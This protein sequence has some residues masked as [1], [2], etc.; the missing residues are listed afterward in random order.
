M[1]NLSGLGLLLTEDMLQS[2]NKM[3]A[4]LERSIGRLE[5][6][7]DVVIEDIKLISDNMTALRASFD[8]LEKGRLSNLEV[9][10]ASLQ[11]KVQERARNTALIYS[12]TISFA[13]SIL[14]AIITRYFS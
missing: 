1:Q 7:V 13:I 14:S 2:Q 12:G 11:A 3:S 10:F 9:S 5:G 4:N 6:K 8:I